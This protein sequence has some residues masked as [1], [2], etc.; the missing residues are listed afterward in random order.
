MYFSAEFLV[1]EKGEGGGDS[2]KGV[3]WRIVVVILYP[4]C[5]GG[6]INLHVIKLH[7]TN[8]HAHAH[9][10]KWVK[11]ITKEISE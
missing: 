5:G 7:R 4:D 10:H 6:L 1:V 8:A 11:V 3:T 9:S 2:N